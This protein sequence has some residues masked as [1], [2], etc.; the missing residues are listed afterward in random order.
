MLYRYVLTSL[1]YISA[2]GAIISYATQGFPPTLWEAFGIDDLIRITRMANVICIIT[3]RVIHDI[4]CLFRTPSET[5]K[6]MFKFF[7][8]F[9]V[10]GSTKRNAIRLNPCESREGASVLGGINCDTHFAT[11][12]APRFLEFSSP[13]LIPAAYSASLVDEA[14]P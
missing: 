12:L 7:L 13:W 11:S 8:R 5:S 4:F 14:H 10:P 6:S 3:G 1:I 9:A 2:N